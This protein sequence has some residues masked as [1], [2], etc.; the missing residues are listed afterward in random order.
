MLIWPSL[1]PDQFTYTLEQDMDRRHRQIRV[2]SAILMMLLLALTF[3]AGWIANDCLGNRSHGFWLPFER[4]GT[5]MRAKP[6]IYSDEE[7]RNIL[8]E[9][10]RVWLFDDE[11]SEKLKPQR[12]HGG[13]I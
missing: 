10:E 9:W 12:T 5:T 7:L 4:T 8:K 13:V 1:V 2:R 6:R 3:G 11:D